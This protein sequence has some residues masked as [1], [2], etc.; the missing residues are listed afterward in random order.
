[1]RRLV[2]LEY[3]VPISRRNPERLDDDVVDVSSSTSS[4]NGE[5]PFRIWILTRGIGVSK[6]SENSVAQNFPPS[7][8]PPLLYDGISKR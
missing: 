7:M 6:I 1:M 5:R 3:L 4:S 2:L 8:G